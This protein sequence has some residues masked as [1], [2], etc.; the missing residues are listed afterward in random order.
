MYIPTR[1]VCC[2]HIG[3]CCQ[4]VILHLTIMWW[5]MKKLFNNIGCFKIPKKGKKIQT[6]LINHG[7]MGHSG[8][9]FQ[10]FYTVRLLYAIIILQDFLNQWNYFFPLLDGFLR[11]GLDLS[12][13]Y[14]DAHS[15]T[16]YKM[17]LM[18]SLVFLTFSFYA[19][20]NTLFIMNYLPLYL[21]AKCEFWVN[22]STKNF[23]CVYTLL[24]F[25]HFQQLGFFIR[26]TNKMAFISIN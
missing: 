25:P 3:Y 2:Q 11:C 7:V 22:F 8:D 20:S 21:G 15:F 9:G 1:L 16:V 26:A 4:W 5:N 10:S 17:E 23:S 13:E 14:F 18:A 19:K 6:E 12:I 24:Q